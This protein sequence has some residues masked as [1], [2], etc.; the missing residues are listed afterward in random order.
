[1]RA[2]WYT[3]NATEIHVIP[4]AKTID[5]HALAKITARLCHQTLGWTG[6]TRYPVH[7]HAAEQMDLDHPQ[8]RRSALPEDTEADPTGEPRIEDS[9]REE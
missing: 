6:R 5:S 8:Y 9:P 2:T 4:I 3:M 1:M 7:L